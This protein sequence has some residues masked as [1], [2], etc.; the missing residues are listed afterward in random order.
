MKFIRQHYLIIIVL[1]VALS[2]RF[3]RLSA[4]LTFLEDEGR[5]L[6]VVHKMLDTF[7]PVLL[8][9]QTSTG[10][11]YL[12]PLYYYLITPALF[13]SRMDPLGPAIFIGLTGALTVYLLYL[14]GTKWFGKLSGMLAAI[15]YALLPLP[16][17][18]TRNSW[19]PNLAPLLSLLL[20]HYLVKIIEDKSTAKKPFFILG[21]LGGAIVQMHYMAL[22]FLVGVGVTLIYYLRH[23]GSKLIKGIPLAIIGFVIVLS[24]F[25]IF[26]IRNNFVNTHAI[27]RFVTAKEEKN[28]RYQLPV[29]LW[30]NKVESTTT[31]VF[32]SLF[33]RDA[34]TP[35]PARVAITSFV[36]VVLILGWLTNLKKADRANR[37]FRILFLTFLIPLALTGIYQ[38]NIHLHYL[39]FFFPLIYLLVA[40]SR[41]SIPLVL[42]CLLYVTPQLSGY[43]NG[44][45]TNQVIRAQEVATYVVKAAGNEPYNLISAS[46]THTTPYLYFTSISAHP[47]TTQPAST[48]FLVCQARPCSDE[49]INSPFLFITGQAHPSISAYL[50][51]PLYN[52]FEGEREV[53]SNDHVSHGAWV[54]KLNV[55]I[56]P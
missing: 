20:L 49:D 21:L 8:G 3:Y 22:L 40:R 45:G 36:T 24:P 50:G 15:M 55:K 5:D 23:N 2:L 26:E 6:L 18:F 52:Y 11:M 56:R 16:V 31:R 43:L 14:F 27:T 7:R 51:H 41:L 17:T 39:G 35:D 48:V 4:T 30:F 53:V 46:G 1:I 19:N 44:S 9:P 32:S 12:G 29:S 25:I 47:P 34:L 28:I 54:A 10:N 33:G 37:I 13:L 42:G 38:E